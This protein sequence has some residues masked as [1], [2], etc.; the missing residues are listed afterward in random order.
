[1]LDV[2][3][4]SLSELEEKMAEKQKLHQQEKHIGLGIAI[5]CAIGSAIGV[6]SGN[7]A[8]WISIGIAIGGGVGSWSSKRTP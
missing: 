5:G 6:V 7:L 2:L 8:L 3:I 4:H 1:M